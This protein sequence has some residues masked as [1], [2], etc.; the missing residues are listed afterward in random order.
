MKCAR[1]G[2]N[3]QAH[4]HMKHGFCCQK[5]MLIGGHGPLCQHVPHG[6]CL[7]KIDA[8]PHSRTGGK[9][10]EGMPRSLFLLLR[11]FGPST[12]ITWHWGIGV[13]QDRSRMPRELI[14]Y[15]GPLGVHKTSDIKTWDAYIKLPASTSRSDEEIDHF[16]ARWKAAH[17]LY[18]AMFNNCQ[19]FAS[20]LHEFLVGEELPY[21]RVG[22]A[23][24]KGII[25]GMLGVLNHGSRGVFKSFKEGAIKGAWDIEQHQPQNDTRAVWLKS[26]ARP[27]KPREA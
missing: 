11:H 8:S 17:P 4:P 25:G 26:G 27:K 24:G 22:Q 7:P 19:N 1:S 13:G 12:Q 5:C 10:A 3:F 18:D 23:V 16:I 15:N 20:D 14:D 9:G 2:C 21:P 6:M